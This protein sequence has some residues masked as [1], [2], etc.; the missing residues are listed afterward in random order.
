MV[1]RTAALVT[2][3]A[4]LTGAGV[5]S[6]LASGRTHTTHATSKVCA[7]SSAIWWTNSPKLHLPSIGELNTLTW[8]D[9]W[10][11]AGDLTFARHP[12]R[13]C[14]VVRC[15]VSVSSTATSSGGTVIRATS[16][17]TVCAS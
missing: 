16:K 15:T 10:T 6:V 9:A 13:A 3:L 2:S 17:S 11:R 14:R 1:Y 5:G 8:L 7:P 4:L 12:V